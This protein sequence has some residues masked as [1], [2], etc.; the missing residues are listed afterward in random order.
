MSPIFVLDFR[1]IQDAKKKNLFCEKADVMQSESKKLYFQC[2]EIKYRGK[3]EPLF[4]F[5]D[6]NEVTTR[7]KF[8]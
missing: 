4:N 8:V 1:L 7:D 3:K 6:F 2:S 5:I